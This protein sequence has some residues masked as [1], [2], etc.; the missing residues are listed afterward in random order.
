VPRRMA[1][2]RGMLQIETRKNHEFSISNQSIIAFPVFNVRTAVIGD[3]FEH[4]PWS[5][6]PAVGN[7]ACKGMNGDRLAERLFVNNCGNRSV[8]FLIINTVIQALELDLVRTADKA[9][10]DYSYR[11][12]LFYIFCGH[13]LLLPLDAAVSV[14]EISNLQSCSRPDP[15]LPVAQRHLAQNYGSY[16]GAQPMP[17]RTG[18][19]SRCYYG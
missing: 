8:V 1:D 10:S 13:R 18:R 2:R 17:N 6:P 7:A 19:K 12:K 5:G 11:E 4:G 3:L 15:A 14:D 16:S 9:K